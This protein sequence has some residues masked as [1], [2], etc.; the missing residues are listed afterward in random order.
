MM[1]PWFRNV[2]L[3]LLLTEDGGCKGLIDAWTGGQNRERTERLRAADLSHLQ[4][5]LCFLSST[6]GMLHIRII[7]R[8]RQ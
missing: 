3:S 2:V 7:G 1:F 5:H 4:H 8:E 6:R